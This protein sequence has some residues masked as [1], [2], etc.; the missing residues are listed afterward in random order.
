MFMAAPDVCL[1]PPGLPL[2]YVNVALPSMA[3]IFSPNVLTAMMPSLT[4]GSLIPMTSGDEAG[5]LHWTF[6]GLAVVTM[7]FARVFFNFLPAATLASLTAGNRFNAPIGSIIVPAMTN[8]FAMRRV[9]DAAPSATPAEEALSLARALEA[10]APVRGRMLAG[11]VGYLEIDLFSLDVPARA[12][13][14]IGGLVAQGM[15]ALWIDLR[16]NPGG[17]VAAALELAGDFLPPG[18]L[19]CTLIDEDGDELERRARPGEPHRFPLFLRVNGGTASASELFAGCLSIHG[20]AV[21]AGERTY[22]KGAGR[23]LLP[24][25]AGLRGAAAG[26][27]LPDGRPIG[28]DGLSPD[29]A[30]PEDGD[31]EA[32]VHLLSASSCQ[33]WGTCGAPSRSQP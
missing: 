22:G 11:G 1:T 21:L 4:V 18:T 10:G 30:F 12:H 28:A 19:L 13:A 20:R 17:D 15:R 6:K 8:V 23:V 33:G 32:L 31:V 5:T 26:V 25:A 16:D 7:S 3:A 14:V 9:E 24:S 2:P 27:R 29:I